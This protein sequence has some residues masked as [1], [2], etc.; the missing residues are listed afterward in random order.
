[1]LRYCSALNYPNLG[2][3]CCKQTLYMYI[4]IYMYAG[5]TIVGEVP[6]CLLLH[7]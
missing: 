5:K 2:T 6:A 1:M 7:W 3:I 4:H